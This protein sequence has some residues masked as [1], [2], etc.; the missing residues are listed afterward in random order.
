M[1]SLLLFLIA[2][3]FLFISGSDILNAGNCLQ[4]ENSNIIDKK[5]DTPKRL[6]R[7]ES[8]FGIHFDFHADTDCV[9]IGKRTTPEMVES[10]LKKV[11]PDFIQIDCKGHPGLT[12]YP[13][14]AGNPA[15]G[16]S[17][18]PL[19]IWREVTA[20]YGVALYMHYSGVYDRT[21]IEKDSLW[22]RVNADG[23]RDKTMNSVFGPYVDKL[24]IPQF[25]ELSDKYNVDGVWVDGDCWAV[26]ND[27][28]ENVIKAFQEKT[29]IKN[30]PKTKT[31][32]NYFE[33]CEFN[34]QGY[35]N[36][37]RHYVDEMHKHNPEFQVASNWSFSS[38]MPEPVDINVDFI[39]G[40]F[41]Y[42]NSVNSARFE[43]RCMARQGKPWDLMSW[44]FVFKGGANHNYKSSIQLMQEAAVVMALGGGF[45]AY[46]TQNRDGSVSLWKMNIMEEVGKFCRER[47]KYCQNTE[48]VPQV[49][50]LFSK[51]DFYRR[52]NSLYGG[53]NESPALKG[54]LYSL[55]D[56][57]YSTEILSEH[58]LKG[59]MDKY[60]VI[61]VPEIYY[62]EPE[63]K[64]ELINY[65]KN[66]GNL[67]IIGQNSADLFREELGFEFSKDTSKFELFFLEQDDILSTVNAP[68]RQILLKNEEEAYGK[69]FKNQ[70]TD[71]KPYTAG[72][73]KNFGK[74]KIAAVYFDFGIQY[75]KGASYLT[76]RYLN[77]IMEKLFTKPLVEVKGSHSVDVTIRKIKGKLAINLVNISGFHNS[78]S[79]DCFDEI[80][81]IGPL[82][83]TINSGTIPKS[84]TLQ[85]G[86]KTLKFTYL[87]GAVKFKLPELKIHNIIVM[88]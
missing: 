2:I 19:K 57:Q 70:D 31:D 49:A 77:S 25:K 50:L 61:V 15:P 86:N 54:V 66:G 13:T 53:W 30:I 51:A 52:L 78:N 38:F 75:F 59:N 74:G 11:K 37:V 41:N 65:A 24:V 16:I 79:I 69:I 28:S 18:D 27:Y 10:I 44:G 5:N 32:P 14:K 45:Q 9:D 58:H 62:L 88:E 48:S 12:S 76:R 1:K 46:F 84:L 8:F 40:D 55:L 20:K 7:A 4:Q 34:R 43:G 36:Y 71:L 47:Q 42:L 82:D 35:K 81:V 33:F 22:A 17:G 67:V 83:I 56:M 39:S 21:A 87:S 6:K 73:I 3:T 26:A 72:S 80:P 85:P 23:L 63:F 64:A 60:P 68:Y 29:G